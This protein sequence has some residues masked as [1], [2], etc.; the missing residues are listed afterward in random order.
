[1]KQIANI[2]RAGGRGQSKEQRQF[3]H[4]ISTR[5]SVWKVFYGGCWVVVAYDKLR[6]NVATVLPPDWTP[7]WKERAACN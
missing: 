1:M 5:L 3:L 2:I 7:D 6:H 4:T